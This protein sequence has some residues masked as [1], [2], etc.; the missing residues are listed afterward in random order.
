M[1]F[2]SE[3]MAKIVYEKDK[4][5]ANFRKN[6]ISHVP[7]RNPKFFFDGFVAPHY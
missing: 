6:S 5:A 3:I 4:K 2:H 7:L 1:G